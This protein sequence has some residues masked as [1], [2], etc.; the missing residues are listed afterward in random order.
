MVS[1]I[2]NLCVSH[3]LALM[4]SLKYKGDG[5]ARF[6]RRALWTQIVFEELYYDFL[7]PN[8]VPGPLSSLLLPLRY[9]CYPT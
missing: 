9:S 4:R 2:V 7:S 5:V 6:L 8:R 1:L 3:S